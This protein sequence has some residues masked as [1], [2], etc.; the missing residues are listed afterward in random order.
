MAALARSTGYKWATGLVVAS[1]VTA[2]TL[3][4]YR[5]DRAGPGRAAGA[6]RSGSSPVTNLGQSGRATLGL[7]NTGR[8]LAVLGVAR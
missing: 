6:G 4:A 8:H 1:N 7:L 2:F 5:G 3:D